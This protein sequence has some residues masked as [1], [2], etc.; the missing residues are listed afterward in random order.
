MNATTGPDEGRISDGRVS[1]RWP[2]GNAEG[3]KAEPLHKETAP[4]VPRLDAAGDVRDA[5]SRFSAPDLA[6]PCYAKAM[7]PIP[8]QVVT[9][10]TTGSYHARYRPHAQAFGWTR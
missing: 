9:A 4:A 3:G 6:L 8:S 10:V 7:P 1:P 5:G 2:P